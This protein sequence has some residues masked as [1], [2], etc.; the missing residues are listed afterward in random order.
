AEF[1][2]ESIALALERR[3]AP[4]PVGTGR[5]LEAVAVLGSGATLRHCAALA[6]LSLD[7]AAGVADALVGA[8]VLVP[9]ALEFIH[10]VVRS[11]VT[12]R[13]GIGARGLTHGRAARLLAADGV[14]PDRLAPHL[15]QTH[16]SGDPWVVATL[17]A[18]A[19]TAGERGTPD[20]AEVYL[21]RALA[22]P[23]EP[24]ERPLVLHELGMALTTRRHP[25][26]P[27]LFEAALAGIDDTMQRGDLALAAV[28]ACNIA[29]RL[30]EALAICTAG[31]TGATSLEPA[32][33]LRLEAEMV[34]SA[35]MDPSTVGLAQEWLVDHA[36]RRPSTGT[37]ADGLALVLLASAVTMRSGPAAEAVALLHEA[38]TTGVLEERG[39]IVLSMLIN[40]LIFNEELD[41][42]ARIAG[43]AHRRCQELASVSL[44]AHYSYLKGL[45]AHRRGALAEAES[46]MRSCYEFNRD[47][48]TRTGA[49]WAMAGLV[50][51]LT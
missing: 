4:L 7:A 18:A 27:G 29:M 25:D 21:R 28:R 45:T 2:P 20:T 14:P 9:P 15:L 8:R 37:S 39:S 36:E 34:A 19:K 3:L 48:G 51:V 47:A 5:F 12:R 40:Q 35:W 26:A 32:P 50:E 33:R 22:E 16:P 6:G 17:R 44:V 23:P 30:P 38:L 49:D 42:A 31:L 11:A 41:T 43:E 24:G 1:G 13:I 10:P 46:E